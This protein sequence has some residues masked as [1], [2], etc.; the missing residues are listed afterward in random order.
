VDRRAPLRW[1][2][3]CATWISQPYRSYDR[4]RAV[5]LPADVDVT[6]TV[7]WGILEGRGTNLSK[8]GLCV[9]LPEALS[10]GTSV[11]LR[12]VTFDRSGFA[13]VCRCLERN[14]AY[15]IGLQFQDGLHIDDRILTGFDYRRMGGTGSWNDPE[16]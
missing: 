14:G 7:S 1:I 9:L 3:D 10:P 16:T 4:R 11:F 8:T 15:E 13:S 12:V 6:V 5:R 2:R